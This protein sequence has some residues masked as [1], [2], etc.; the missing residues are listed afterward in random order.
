MKYLITFSLLISLFVRLQ[1]DERGIDTHPD[2]VFYRA[3]AEIEVEYIKGMRAL[4]EGAAQVIVFQIEPTPIEVD[5][6]KDYSDN[7]YFVLSKL[8]Q[9]TAY[10]IL[11]RSVIKDD[12]KMKQ[13]ADVILP[14]EDHLMA[15]SRPLPDFGIRFIDSEGATIFQTTFSMKSYSASLYFPKYSS[16]IGIDANVVKN[17]LKD[18]GFDTQ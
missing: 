12:D 16:R 3:L 6:F 4:S 11:R 5:P 9:Q 17:L 2:A 14:S 13:W 8:Q 18:Q 7:E 10:R 1:A 15:I